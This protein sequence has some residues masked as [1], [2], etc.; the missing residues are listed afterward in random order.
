MADLYCLMAV[1]FCIA[2]DCNVIYV[3]KINYAQKSTSYLRIR[4]KNHVETGPNPKQ[5]YISG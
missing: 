2:V 3:F 4:K 1:L 5:H